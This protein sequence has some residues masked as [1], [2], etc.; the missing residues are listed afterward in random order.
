M[1]NG[2]VISDEEWGLIKWV[3]RLLTPL[4][5]VTI[6]GGFTAYLQMTSAQAQTE[7]RIQTLEQRRLEAADEVVQI[8]H[9]QTEILQSQH[10]I[11]LTVERVET[12]QSNLRDQV[13][14]IKA[15]NTEILRLL[16]QRGE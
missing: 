7:Q 5:I 9:K 2:H 3:E 16:R 10:S 11:E 1:S 14:D 6:I 12:N 4:L 13:T 8:K 15:Q